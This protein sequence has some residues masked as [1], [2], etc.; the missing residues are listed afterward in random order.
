MDP[1]QGSKALPQE[2][3]GSSGFY[4]V[5][6]EEP[7]DPLGHV[8]SIPEVDPRTLVGSKDPPGDR[9]HLPKESQGSSW[10]PQA[11]ESEKEPR[12]PSGK[13]TSPSADVFHH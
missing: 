5:T 8:P 3:Q 10:V 12:R 6:L 4:L 13:A 1:L 11:L 2:P 7:C 9:R